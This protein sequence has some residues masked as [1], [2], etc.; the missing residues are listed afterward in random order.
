MSLSALSAIDVKAP[1]ATVAKPA[2]ET[3]SF[4]D[5]V[6]KEISA[7][8][9]AS[10]D[11]V[12]SAGNGRAEPKADKIAKASNPKA[13]LR[14]AQKPKARAASSSKD[15]PSDAG[16]E[17][18]SAEAN[19]SE[20]LTAAAPTAE[21]PEAAMDGHG[22]KAESEKA[23]AYISAA[24]ASPF[25]VLPEL[26]PA[27]PQPVENEL[28]A[29]AVEASG[30]AA[31]GEALA[32]LAPTLP[33]TTE[34]GVEQGPEAPIAPNAAESKLPDSDENLLAT[35]APETGKA[36]AASTA[37]D[38]A[39][40]ASDEAAEPVPAGKGQSDKA[41][42]NSSFKVE[43]KTAP[44]PKEGNQRPAAEARNE[45][46]ATPATPA[47]PASSSEALK[48]AQ[49]ATPAEPAAKA[50]PV[51]VEVNA[52]PAEPVVASAEPARVE[53]NAKPAEPAAPA[54]PARVEVVAKPAEPA[55]PA[56]PARVEVIPNPAEPAAPAEPARAERAA[57]PATPAAPSLKVEVADGARPENAS[58]EGQVFAASVERFAA[59]P[60]EIKAPVSPRAR[61]HPIHGVKAAP[62]ANKAD[63]LL[64]EEGLGES[65]GE[66]TVKAEAPRETAG[67][68]LWGKEGP[69]AAQQAGK[70]G[71][72]VASAKKAAAPSV[73]LT[74]IPP[75]KDGAESLEVS[76][77]A[78][79]P[80][81]ESDVFAAPP[82]LEEKG[83]HYE[84]ASSEEKVSARDA[85]GFA[86]ENELG[87]AKKEA[88]DAPLIQEPKAALQAEDPRM[89]RE[90]ARQV[91]SGL[92]MALLKRGEHV[93][94]KLNPEALGKV[95]V[96]LVRTSEGL[97]ARFKVESPEARD[98]LNAQLPEMKESIEA[99]GVNLASVK[100]LLGD[101]GAEGFGPGREAQ[102]RF[103][104][105]AG[106]FNNQNAPEETPVLESWKPW[107]FEATV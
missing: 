2:P 38:K 103:G 9:E 70:A 11:A 59:K 57:A 65:G 40:P 26:V 24:K 44:E 12:H 10:S 67:W 22:E 96:D 4:Q 73:G 97:T 33:E 42:D 88:G 25:L 99:R 89:A 50:E 18:A 72:T 45:R 92:S 55:A 47:V 61:K 20:S 58:V 94:V 13:S 32:S 78:V 19:P 77:K 30:P 8:R 29:A 95:E 54:E 68:R 5:L 15:E 14:S 43:V 80:A 35:S 85:G 41:I 64:L 6:G 37:W 93:V 49:P 34:T 23:E 1:T 75:A 3:S 51:R 83:E 79:K 101:T 84:I 107:G 16:R 86:I 105:G 98:A 63:A 21:S 76:A 53:A 31:D 7:A 56:E 27:Q 62:A 81:I 36:A 82:L 90:I 91:K 17:A 48:S 74:E 71:E 28:P 106:R 66:L 52:K 46:A 100:V 87:L 104:R 60:A 39:R 102:R 69:T